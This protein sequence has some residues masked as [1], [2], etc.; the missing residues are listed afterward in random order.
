[1]K[2]TTYIIEI[3]TQKNEK[4]LSEGG[5]P[6]ACLPACFMS[7]KKFSSWVHWEVFCC[8]WPIKLRDLSHVVLVAPIFPGVFFYH[9]FYGMTSRFKPNEG[10]GVH[11]YVEHRLLFG[12]INFFSFE[13]QISCS[14]FSWSEQNNFESDLT[15]N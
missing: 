7:T 3:T 5:N 10:E 11:F 12:R 14:S 4:Y 13:S 8:F 6:L 1:M 9:S 2:S 15:G